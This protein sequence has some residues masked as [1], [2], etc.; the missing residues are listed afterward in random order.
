[1]G[2]PRKPTAQL[3]L[4]GAFKKNPQRRRERAGEPI[5]TSAVGSPPRH[6]N[7]AAKAIW[8]R[9]APAAYWL[10]EVDRE[11]LEVFCILMAEAETN[12]AEMQASRISV[13]NRF[14]NDLGLTPG[15][16][17][18][19]KAPEEDEAQDNPFALFN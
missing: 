16:R 13:L 10:T 18:K 15:A 4:E 1:M 2:R 6:M 9:T 19:V 14:M 12:L 11:A 17:T 7:D 3:E 8:R 5:V